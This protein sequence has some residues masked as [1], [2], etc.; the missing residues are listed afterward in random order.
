[1]GIV[2]DLRRTIQCIYQR[3]RDILHYLLIHIPRGLF[4][5]LIEMRWYLI[6][7]LYWP[8]FLTSKVNDFSLRSFQC[9]KIL[10]LLKT[11]LYVA[12]AREK[13][14]DNGWGLSRL[15]SVTI[16]ARYVY[17][18]SSMSEQKTMIEIFTRKTFRFVGILFY[19]QDCLF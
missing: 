8:W 13:L 10:N 14:Q 9:H 6:N 5:T 11:Q 3:E 18:P 16:K 17:V 4:L 2:C 12:W 15:S 19:S 7:E 1:M